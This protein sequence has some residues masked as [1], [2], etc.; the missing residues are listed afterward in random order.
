MS[1]LMITTRDPSL[2]HPAFEPGLT[3]A[4][5]ELPGLWLADAL[6]LT[7]QILKAQNIPRPPREKL[8]ELLDFLGGHPLS[9]QL[10]V[11]HLREHTPEQLIAEFDTLLPGFTTGAGKARNESLCVSLEFSLRR[12]GQETRALLPDLAVFQGGAM[13]VRIL[14]I[15]GWKIATWR[16][17]RDELARAGL[18][19]VDPS[20]SLGVKTDEGDFSGHYVRFHPTLFPHLAPQLAP[21]R[22]AELEARFRQSYYELARY[23]YQQDDKDPLP[24]R[25]IVVRELPNLRRALD[26]MLA[27]PLAGGTEGGLDTAADLADSIAKFMNY[28]GRWSERDAILSQVER[29]LAAVSVLRRRFASRIP[30]ALESR[31]ATI[32]GRPRGAGRTRVPRP[33]DQIG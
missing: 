28:F 9:I 21:A 12:L 1:R 13:E 5:T 3:A 7:A 11:P 19:T 10:V 33:T 30:D 25:A 29:A 16:Q 15:T 17:V 6:D 14:P 18:L 27:S 8:A 32:A 22:R 24:T 23:L 31:R 2:P 4:H 26:L 20:V